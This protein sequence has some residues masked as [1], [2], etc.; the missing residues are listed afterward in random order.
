[1]M[2]RNEIAGKEVKPV[3]SSWML[4]F[5]DLLSLM[6]T[7]FVLLFS[8]N[9]VQFESWKAVVET[10]TDEFNPNRPR[11]VLEPTPPPDQLTIRKGAGLNLTYLQVLFERAISARPELEGTHVTRV[12]DGVQISIPAKL[13]FERK[14][15]LLQTGAAKALQELA[16]T[17]IQ[18]ENRIKV[19]GHTDAVPISSGRF[20]SNWELSMTRARIVAG[21]LTDAGYSQPITVLGYADTGINK[22]EGLSSGQRVAGLGVLQERIDI[23]IVAERKEMGPYDLF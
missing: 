20:R 19:A 17:L 6:L 5:A 4:T 11:I 10:M 7:F 23:M 18:I 2:P 15:T 12:S 8:M 22:Y 1:M 21:I 16:G 3:G 13:L 14:E 9:S